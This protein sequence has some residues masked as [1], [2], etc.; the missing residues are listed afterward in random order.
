MTR[1]EGMSEK[2]LAEHRELILA[3]MAQVGP[4]RRGSLQQVWRKCGNPAC[5]C[6]KPG[7]PGHGPKTQWTRTAKG[8]GGSRGQA[9][10]PVHARQVRGELDLFSQFQA[11]VDD[12]VEVNEQI[13]VDRASAAMRLAGP[14]RQEKG[15]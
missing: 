6:A 14:G 9:I 7:D 4:F 12:F 11:L 15:S 1:Y 5:H 8:K 2:E 10:T 3:R 13:C